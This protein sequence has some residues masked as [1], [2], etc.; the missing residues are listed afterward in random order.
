MNASTVDRQPLNF[1][2]ATAADWTAARRRL[3]G[4]LR[5]RDVDADRAEEIAQA[6]L[7]ELLTA[8]YNGDQCPRTPRVA[9]G[10]RIATAKRYGIAALT[11]GGARS[12]YRRRVGL[13]EVQPAADPVSVRDVAP[14]WTDPARMAEAG[15]SLA[16]RMPRL[17]MHARRIGTTPAGLALRATGWGEEQ[18]PGTVP[19]VTD[20][21][22]GF[23]PPPRGCPGLRTDTDPN[24]ASRERAWL[25]CVAAAERVGLTISS[26]HRQ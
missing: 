25:E 19:S 21:G 11:K 7:A 12:R 17:A 18:E 14:S 13:E 23:T 9:V 5:T 16:E 20:V 22:P 6:V 24:P 2:A 1:P 4:W 26:R 3:I 15:E 8:K 10:W